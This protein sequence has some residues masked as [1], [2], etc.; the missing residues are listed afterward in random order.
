MYGTETLPIDRVSNKEHFFWKNQAENTQQKLTPDH[1]IILV[2][3]P[4]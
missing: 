1:F 2:N 3:H 4:K